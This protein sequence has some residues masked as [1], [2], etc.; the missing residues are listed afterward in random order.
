LVFILTLV[1]ATFWLSF[2]RVLSE[3]D[4]TNQTDKQTATTTELAK[5]TEPIFSFA[6]I[7]DTEI[8][9]DPDSSKV[10]EATTKEINTTDPA[11]LINTGDLTAHGTQSEFV[12]FDKIRQTL[13]ISLYPVIGNNDIATDG[14]GKYFESYF[15]KPYYSFDFEDVHFVML[16]NSSAF[17]GFDLAQRNWLKDDLIL[18]DGK[19]LILAMHRPV[20]LD[21]PLFRNVNELSTSNV[22]AFMD[23]IR[24]YQDKIEQIFTGHIHS[25]LEYKINKIIPVT[26]TGGG[27]AKPQFD[28]IKEDYHYLQVQV[29][30]ERL[31]VKKISLGG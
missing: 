7:G 27:G 15:D 13:D 18:N 12:N 16:D 20:N 8:S 21:L 29:Y 24:P 4:S 22:S 30:A 23:I 31:E 6:V 3:Q 5:S 2:R 1:G 17:Y 9:S 14:S 11:F 26:V 28:F 19:R 10:F 25:F